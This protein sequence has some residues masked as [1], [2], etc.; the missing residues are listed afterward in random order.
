MSTLV[1]AEHDNA[2]IKVATLN[3][4]AAAQALGGDVDILVAGSSCDA[5]AQKTA[6]VEW[7]HEISPDC[8]RTDRSARRRLVGGLTTE[9]HQR[10]RNSKFLCVCH[11]EISMQTIV[12]S[13]KPRFTGR[14][15]SD[16]PG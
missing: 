9:L 5:A 13:F 12:F 14:K 3:A 6:S 15:D 2:T 10:L 8:S 1:I 11:P 7:C 16:S 4:V